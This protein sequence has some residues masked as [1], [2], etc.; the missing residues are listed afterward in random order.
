M[1]E[2]KIGVI[3]GSGLYAMEGL[4]DVENLSLETPFGAPSDDYVVGKLAG[5]SVAFLARHGVGHRFLPSELNFRANIFG[6]K[7]LGVEHILSAS[8]V[9]SLK[10]D[11][12]PLDVV[13]PD[14]FIDRTRGRI[15]TFFGNGLAAHVEFSKPF[16]ERLSK[17]M[18]EAGKKI[19]ARIR[20]GGTYVCM[21]GP[22]FSTL[23][24]SELYR[25]W[26]AHV[27]GMTNLQEAKLAREAEIGYA[28][29]ALVTDYDCW[30]VSHSSVTVEQIIENL[31]K[32]AESARQIIVETV[33]QLDLDQPS[34]HA[35]ALQN[36]FI[37]QPD[38]IP[39]A[40]KR[41]LAPIIGK[42]IK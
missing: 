27:I 26:G 4:E 37:T 2:A 35:N 9:G 32:N 30:H 29:M 40:I 23:A 6:F 12:H 34:P 1:A 25:S 33:S 7:L 39:D 21:E 38:Y 13:I 31:G 11:I 41:D 14:Q 24:E 19:D 20:R 36:A 5:K 10:E 22:Q 3:G 17:L 15:S 28:T 8:A 16:C 18:Y 42:Y